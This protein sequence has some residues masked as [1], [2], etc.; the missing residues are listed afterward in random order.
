M[1][2]RQRE[3]AAHPVWDSSSLGVTRPRWSESSP[4][5]SRS[6]V[7]YPLAVVPPPETPP[8]HIFSSG[9]AGESPQKT[10]SSSHLLPNWSGAFSAEIKHLA[11]PSPQASQANLRRRQPP[12]HT[13]S[14]LQFRRTSAKGKHLATPPPQQVRRTSAKC[15][16]LATP[17]L[18]ATQANLRRNQTPRYTFSPIGRAHLPQEATTSSHLLPQ[19]VGRTLRR[20][21][22]SL[23]TFS[24]SY[25][26]EPPQEAATLHTFSPP[27]GRAH[28]PQEAARRYWQKQGAASW[29]GCGW[30]GGC[31]AV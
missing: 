22:P 2:V 30:W 16:H 4:C 29:V 17:S 23:H 6:A 8:H 18:P 19:L 26:G 10:A 13:F 31:V 5:D 25:S 12:L 28:P 9:Y 21:Q 11:T 3:L 1:W 24:P 20:K 7:P 14:P 15:K 27:A